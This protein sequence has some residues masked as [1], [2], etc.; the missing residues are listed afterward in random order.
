MYRRPLHILCFISK[1][2]LQSIQRVVIESVIND[3][4]AMIQQADSSLTWDHIQSAGQELNSCSS[5]ANFFR[6]VIALVA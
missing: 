6:D 5:P 1:Y 3:D 4:M 2:E